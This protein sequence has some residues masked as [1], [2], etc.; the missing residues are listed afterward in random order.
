[1]KFDME[2]WTDKASKNDDERGLYERAD[3]YIDA[4]AAHTDLRVRRDGAALA[5]GGQWE[6]H[7]I[8]QRDFLQSIGLL[9]WHRLLD[10]GC[11]TGRFARRIVPWLEPGKYTGVDISPAAL[12]NCAELARTE[13]WHERRPTFLQGNG[14]LEAVYGMEFN[15]IWAHSVFTHLPEDAIDRIFDDLHEFKWDRFYFTYKHQP[16]PW[17]SG[18]KQFQYPFEFF[19]EIATKHGFKASPEE[20]KWP[21][22]Q[23]TAFVLP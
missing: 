12:T 2:G 18:L 3:N 9:P 7:G 11:G 17:R 1:M 6:E 19:E 21:G 14:T 4:Y 23:R 10:L 16:K 13:G 8:Y 15:L 20:T 5:I 22:S